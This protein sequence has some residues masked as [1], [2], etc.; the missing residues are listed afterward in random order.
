MTSSLRRDVF[1]ILLELV[2]AMTVENGLLKLT[3]WKE[4]FV[5]INRFKPLY[6]QIP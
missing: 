2:W 1:A 6:C 4:C 3:V 5:H